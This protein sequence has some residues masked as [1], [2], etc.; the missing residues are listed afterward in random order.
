[1]PSIILTW[2]PSN[3]PSVTVQKVQY[4]VSTT[5]SWITAATLSSTASTQTI[6]SLSN[7]TYYDFRVVCVCNGKEL[8]SD[9]KTISIPSA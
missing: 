5:S 6:D 2:T 1:M 9:I 4:K 3:A 7:A 8:A